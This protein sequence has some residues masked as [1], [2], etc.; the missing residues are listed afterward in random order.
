MTIHRF[1]VPACALLALALSGCNSQAEQESANGASKES[2]PVDL[3][4]PAPKPKAPPP[5]PEGLNKELGEA[6]TADT[7]QARALASCRALKGMSGGMPK[8]AGPD[9]IAQAQADLAADPN[10]LG[11]CQASL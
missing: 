1:A 5:A 9:E 11:N 6:L 3:A 10:A 4:S 8:M 7:G 2:A